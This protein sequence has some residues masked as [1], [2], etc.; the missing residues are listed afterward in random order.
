[1]VTSEQLECLHQ[2]AEYYDY[3]WGQP[4]GLT[5]AEQ[6]TR[7][8]LKMFDELLHLGL[9]H[10][11]VSSDVELIKAAGYLHDIGRSR[12]ILQVGD[13][14][15]LGFDTLRQVIPQCV[16][17]E[18]L[19]KDELSILLYC[20]LFHRGHDFS[21]RKEVPLLQPQRTKR[22]A[23]I[24]RIADALDHGPPFGLVENLTVTRQGD[25]ILCRAFCPKDMMWRV[26]SYPSGA[27][28]KADLFRQIYPDVKISFKVTGDK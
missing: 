8:A 15:R 26:E 3:G 27:N 25:S 2:I 17:G 20:V 18:P 23:A 7:L 9:P 21:E 5:H 6:V 11:Q 10:G 19:T 16:T 28:R 4:Y 22:L 12:I 24:L 14:N 13:H 1:M